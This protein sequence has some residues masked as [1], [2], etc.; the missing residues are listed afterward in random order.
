MK[1]YFT[2]V[3]LE[4][5]SPFE[6]SKATSSPSF[7][8]NNDSFAFFKK[9]NGVFVADPFVHVTNGREYLFCELLTEDNKHYKGI[10]GIIIKLERSKEDYEWSNPTVVLEENFHVSY[11]SIYTYNNETFMLVETAEINDVRIYKSNDTELNSWSFFKVILNG[12]YFD[13]TI[14]EFQKNWFMFVCTGKSFSVLELYFSKNLFGPW[15]KHPK[16]P[17]KSDSSSSRPAG[18]ILEW[19]NK[20]YRLAQDCSI[21]YGQSVKAFEITT[22]SKE[23]YEEKEIGI[24]LTE[25]NNGWNSYGMHHLQVYKKK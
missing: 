11:P 3:G 7:F 22:L 17:L 13:P 19:D 6:L 8:I 24:I 9:H 10:K 15:T 4:A 23:D 21:R 5:K 14:F 2:I 20:L 1:N 18:P 16:S 12:K 25:S